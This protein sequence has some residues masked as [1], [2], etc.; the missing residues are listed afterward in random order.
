MPETLLVRHASSVCWKCARLRAMVSALGGY[1][2]L[3]VGIKP[4]SSAC[5]NSA[6]TCARV[7][8]MTALPF[9]FG[10]QPAFA[11]EAA[12]WTNVCKPGAELGSGYWLRPEP[13]EPPPP[14]AHAAAAADSSRVPIGDRF[15]ET[16][17]CI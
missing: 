2:A 1:S 17:R 15:R 7:V 8:P 12:G 3:S 6:R 10:A 16:R 13:F 5:N 9:G 11:A 4:V 14:P